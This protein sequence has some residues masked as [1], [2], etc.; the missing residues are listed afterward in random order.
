MHFATQKCDDEKNTGILSHR[1][2]FLNFWMPFLNPS[3]FTDLQ[4]IFNFW[5]PF[6]NPSDFTD[7]Q[8]LQTS[9]PFNQIFELLII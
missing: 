1:N 4:T 2:V 3:D 8:T 5:M 7:L 6:L 9:R